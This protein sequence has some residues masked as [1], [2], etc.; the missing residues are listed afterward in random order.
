MDNPVSVEFAENPDPR[1]PCILLLDASEPMSGAPIQALNQALVVFDQDIRE[2]ALAQRRI[3]IAVIT[4]GK[5]KVETVQDFVSARQFRAPLLAAGGTAPVGEAINRAIDL[6]R[7][8]IQRYNQ[9]GVAYYRPWVFMIT[10][11]EWSNSEWQIGHE[12]IRGEE[13]ANRLAFFTVGV[14]GANRER[15]AQIAVR[16]PM[17][18]EDLKFADLFLWLSQALQKVSTSRVGE[19][20]ALPPVGWALE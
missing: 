15:L 12:R 20:V 2:D 1:C 13:R 10:C 3:E 18:L 6:L 9:L 4:F 8:R 7:D 11:G 19:Q 17:I 5:G 16:R 14:T